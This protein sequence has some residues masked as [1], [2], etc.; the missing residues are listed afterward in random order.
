MGELPE[1]EK[2][3]TKKIS[4]GEGVDLREVRYDPRRKEQLTSAE[5]ILSHRQALEKLNM[6]HQLLHVMPTEHHLQASIERQQRLQ[7][8][9]KWQAEWREQHSSSEQQKLL[10]RHSGDQSQ[11]VRD[12]L[13]T[14][15]SISK[16]PEKPASGCPCGKHFEGVVRRRCQVCAQQYHHMCQCDD[17][18]GKLCNLCFQKG[19]VR[20]EV[21][22]DSTGKK[23]EE[24]D[25][26]DER[27]RRLERSDLQQI[28][29][30]ERNAQ[31]MVDGA[32]QDKKDAFLTK[33]ELSPD[34][35]RLLEQ[36]T[37]GQSSSPLWFSARK[38]RLTASNFGAV[39]RMMPK[40]DPEN[41]VKRMLSPAKVPTFG[42]A[43]G[44]NVEPTAL[45]EYQDFN[46]KESL[47]PLK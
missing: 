19:G 13:T 31:E 8:Q 47:S 18:T 3:T 20:L 40:T 5:E 14:P 39:F 26:E 44:M 25:E 29:W 37:L 7:L 16:L 41:L 21:G 35:A 34:A 36:A 28:L 43:R 46:D 45:R 42:M 11:Q 24:K 33:L 4:V 9:K 30:R 32:A 1:R 22:P 17:E 38:A 2:L 27:N 10:P 23:Q 15:P 6:N 12:D